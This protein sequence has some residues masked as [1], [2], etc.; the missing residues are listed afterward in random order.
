MFRC[1]FKEAQVKETP[2]NDPLARELQRIEFAK[3]LTLHRVRTGTIM[4]FTGLTQNRLTAYR[5]RW[6]IPEDTR[7]R[8]C[9]P[10]SL[11]IF[12][13]SP[14]ARTETAAVL[15]LCRAFDALPQRSR[16]YAPDGKFFIDVGLRLCE[17]FEAYRACRPAS[18]L[19]FDDLMLLVRELDHGKV[20]RL[21]KCKSCRALIVIASF[22]GTRP[23]CSHCQRRDTK[24]I[25]AS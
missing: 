19:E 20:I 10:Q 18:D 24:M 17:A 5:R 25:N 6:K 23:I 16:D 4:N 13:H 3:R 8:G 7:L 9:H 11:D 15:A 14:E 21:G 2:T 12:L 22:D 1:F